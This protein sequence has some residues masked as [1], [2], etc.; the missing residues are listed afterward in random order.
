MLGGAPI[1]III[2]GRVPGKDFAG[3]F[4]APLVPTCSPGQIGV[5]KFI[6]FLTT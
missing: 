4:Y 2:R 6:Y 3:V 5:L 1:H